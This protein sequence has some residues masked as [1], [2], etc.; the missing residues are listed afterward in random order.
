MITVGP[1]G[2]VRV[3]QEPVKVTE[4]RQ[5]LTRLFRTATDHVVFVRGEK[6]LEFRAVA[7]VLDIASGAGL[8]RVAL[9]TE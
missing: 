1:D 6:G 9:M 4:L 2:T 7:E 8:N 5:R 3:N